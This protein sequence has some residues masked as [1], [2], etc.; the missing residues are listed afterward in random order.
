MNNIVT[1]SII[2]IIL[3]ASFQ[4]VDSIQIFMYKHKDN[5][6]KILK[7]G[8]MRLATIFLAIT[9]F[10]YML[11][12]S[13]WIINSMLILMAIVIATFVLLIKLM[14]KNNIN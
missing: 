2:V 10:A 12:L 3:L 6:E 9:A 4:T 5:P 13:S 8:T 14:Y 11:G 1:F 7:F